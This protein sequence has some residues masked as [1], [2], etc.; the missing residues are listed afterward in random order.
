MILVDGLITYG[1][2]LTRGLPSRTWC[3][4][5]SDASED[6]LHDFAAQ[7]GLRRSW[8]Q[9]RPQASAAHYD[10]LPFRRALAVKLGAIEVTRRDLV[11]RNYDRIQR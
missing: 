7:I 5:V 10:L 11:V 9:L 4:M 3:H 6:E 2:Q 1:A 8:A